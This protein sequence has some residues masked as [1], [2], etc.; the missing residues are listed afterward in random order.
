MKP[1]HPTLFIRL[2]DAM[3]VPYGEDPAVRSA[4][5]AISTKEKG[6]KVLLSFEQDF[7]DLG[8][9]V[10]NATVK[11]LLTLF[12]KSDSTWGQFY[13]LG[14]E[15][16][17]RL[18]DELEGTLFLSMTSSEA[19]CYIKPTR[20]WEETIKRWPKTRIDIEESSKCFA[21]A[22]YAASIFH[23]LLVAE[24]GVIEVAKLLGVAGDK[25]GWGAL[26]RLER[27]LDKPY[28]ERSPIEQKHS[29]LLTQILPLMLAMKESWRHKISHVENKLEWLDTDFSPQL[30]EEIAKAIRGF[31][32]RLATALPS[33]SVTG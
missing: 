13:D 11:K 10:S 14:I 31:M 4:P 25:P 18:Q 28:K 33:E 5:I 12:S 15:L 9:F 8:L 20:D 17:E 19:Q 3:G 1:F 24:L 26:D 22:R 16:Q 27:I 29:E 2:H 7:A 21:C 32:R 6:T 23:V 30:A